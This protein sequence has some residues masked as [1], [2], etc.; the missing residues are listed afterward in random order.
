MKLVSLV[1]ILSFVTSLVYGQVTST[2]SNIETETPMT[3]EVLQSQARYNQIAADAGRYFK[4]GL[5]NMQ[6]N[7]RSQARKD[8][9]KSVE[10]FLFS[11]VDVQSDQKLRECYSQL[12][13]TIYQMEFPTGNQ[14]LFIK[15]LGKTCGWKI[16]NSLVENVAKVIQ[17]ATS[18]ANQGFKEQKFEG[19]KF[20]SSEN[21]Y[22]IKR[23]VIP[24]RGLIQSDQVNSC[25]NSDSPIIQGL[26]LDTPILLIKRD[27]KLDFSRAKKLS[28]NTANDGYLFISPNANVKG[29]SLV[30]YKNSLVI[31][32]VSYSSG[33]PWF[34]LEEFRQKIVDT[35]G[36]SGTWE[37][38]PTKDGTKTVLECRD[39]WV[40]LDKRGE[41]YSLFSKSK[42][43]EA[44]RRKDMIEASK[45][46]AKIQQKKKETFKP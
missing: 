40:L 37:T 32:S 26:R 38:V 8:F 28:I 1:F 15:S 27:S 3:S 10:V 5:L 6:D 11:G 18:N 14:L 17:S 24:G 46:K 41:E 44:R 9:D 22:S 39:F 34:S 33:I 31:I 13:E 43:V 4:Q 12:T 23:D 36:I 30:F 42:I 45:E 29:L 19:S 20:V 2:S 16:E 35:L 21:G 25:Q 7:F